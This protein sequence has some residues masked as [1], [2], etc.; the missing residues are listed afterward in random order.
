MED[1]LRLLAEK[2]VKDGLEEAEAERTKLLAAAQEEAEGIRRA[3]EES[4][5]RIRQSA[6][7]AAASL[8]LQVQSELQQLV[9][10][11][12][13][14]LRADLRHLIQGRV[15]QQPVARQFDQAMPGILRE[16]IQHLYRDA[17]GRL[18]IRLP[19]DSSAALREQLMAAVHDLLQS[20]P[21]LGTD[22]RIGHGFSIQREGEQYVIDFTA[23]DFE[24]VLLGLLSDDLQKLL[25]D[26][27]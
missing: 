2:L 23:A 12:K 7:Q 22:A 14:G 3:A 18:E 9:R 5:A 20:T 19:E 6:E 4:A 16:V 17:H 26:A 8:R 24:A 11:A 1:K 13:E 27:D 25:Q 21:V 15:V 10:R